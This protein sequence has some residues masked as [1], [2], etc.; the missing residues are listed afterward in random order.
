MAIK[1]IGGFHLA[2]DATNQAAVQTLRHRKGR[3]RKP[4]A[5]MARDLATARRLVYLDKEAEQVLGSPAR[6][7]LLA[8]Q[9][10][11]HGLA[12]AVAPGHS[13]FGVMLPYTPLHHLLL[14]A[15]LPVL[16]MTSANPGGEPLCVDDREAERR[17]A[18]L[19]DAILGHDRPIVRSNDDSVL[20]FADSRAV[21]AAAAAEAP[22]APVFIRRGRGFAPGVLPLA[23]EGPAL[24]GVGGELKNT[25][26]L[27]A[28]GRAVLS[29][30]LGDLQNTATYELF[31]R[32]IADLSALFAISPQA[33]ACDLHPDYLSSRWARQ[34][35]AEHDLPLL[36]VQHHHA[37]LAACLAEHQHAGPAIGLILDGT[38]YGPDGTI[39]GGEILLGD[40][41]ACTRFGHLETMPLPGGDAAVAEP[42]RTGL[43]YLR[44]ACA[45][46]IPELPF[47]AAVQSPAPAA[48]GAGVDATEGG[49]FAPSGDYRYRQQ[50]VLTMLA[51]N[52]NCPLTSSCGRLFD[53]VAAICGVCR[54]L[55]Y[56]A[57]AAIELMEL[58]D[59]LAPPSFSYEID[60]SPAGIVLAIS[61]LVRDIAEAVAAGEAVATISRRF[62]YTLVEL[63]SA[64]VERAAAASG[65]QTVAL[66]GGVLQN[67][68]LWQGLRQRLQAAGFTVLVPQKLPP[69]D[70]AI[71]Y[72][73]VAVAR[74]LAGA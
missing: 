65:C 41:A 23:G 51:K 50:M 70:G 9:Q 66:A 42:W 19:A 58:A 5:L 71:A 72:G 25:V 74:R 38:G 47:L 7:I 52:L 68:I 2:V 6:P 34:W 31:Q 3:Q 73:Q 12:S 26:C 1:G 21:S 61:P 39:W 60:S 11:D 14:T 56:E 64:G 69:N 54:R 24:L 15:E 18:G 10:P 17:L 55:D 32:T 8:A 27:A 33:V 63:F 48:P 43:A 13:R 45:G 30:H 20:F 53:A 36:P 4:L 49:A 35:A 67:R 29:Q 59:G 44:Q 22:A 57:Q 40:T 28:D 37:H 62:H 46:E 16:V